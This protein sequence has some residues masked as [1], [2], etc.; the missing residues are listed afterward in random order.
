VQDTPT[1][2][3]TLSFWR[4]ACPAFDTL[5]V[6][7]ALTLN[8][9]QRVLQHPNILNL[10]L[11]GL[12]YS[13]DLSGMKCHLKRLSL[14]LQGLDFQILPRLPILN[15]QQPLVLFST[16]GMLVSTLGYHEV[17]VVVVVVVVVAAADKDQPIRTLPYH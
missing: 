5:S 6:G 9:F 12:Q 11:T 15:L 3:G 14:N 1:L 10:K 2:L 8:N 4:N 13:E 17:S 16:T 7:Y